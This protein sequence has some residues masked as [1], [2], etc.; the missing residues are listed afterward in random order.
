MHR[1]RVCLT[2]LRVRVDSANYSMDQLLLGTL[3]F[4]VLVFLWPTTFMYY[5]FL[6]KVGSL[7]SPVPQAGIGAGLS[8]GSALLLLQVHFSLLGLQACAA[9]LMTCLNNFPVVSLL[10]SLIDPSSLPH[11]LYLQHMPS[12]A[13]TKRASEWEQPRILRAIE[14]LLTELFGLQCG[15]VQPKVRPD[16]IG[17]SGGPPELPCAA[18]YFELRIKSMGLADLL[19]PFKRQLVEALAP[20]SPVRVAHCFILERTQAGAVAL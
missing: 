5:L 14:R 13:H 7:T 10:Q 6:T 1:L 8:R 3:G 20:F 4:T 17:R 12:D 15:S 19:V 18:S 16:A 11:G 9:F 2:S